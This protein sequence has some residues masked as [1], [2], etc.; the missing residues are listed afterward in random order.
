MLH[1]KF[2]PPISFKMLNARKERS[3]FGT[4]LMMSVK[5]H[6]N[7]TPKV[8]SSLLQETSVLQNDN[9]MIIVMVMKMVFCNAIDNWWFHVPW[10]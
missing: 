1:Q 6:E 4:F 2:D 7:A 10:K 8:T 5:V 9:G 3:L